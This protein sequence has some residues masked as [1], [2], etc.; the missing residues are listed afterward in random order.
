MDS[1]EEILR[2]VRGCAT[3]PV[4]K[5]YAF[6]ALVRGEG[7]LDDLCRA[8]QSDIGLTANVLRLANCPLFRCSREIRTV[9]EAAIRLGGWTMESILI[10]GAVAPFLNTAVPGYELPAGVLWRHAISLGAV[11]MELAEQ[12]SRAGRD[13]AFVAGLLAD[14]GKIVLGAFIE[15]DAE[16]IV[17]LAYERQVPFDEAER[18]VLGIDHPEVGAALLEHWLLPE[19]LVA[20]VRWHHRPDQ[21]GPWRRLAEHVHA[22]DVVCMSLGQSLGLDGLNYVC[23]E[24]A[25]AT[26][27]LTGE[28]T[29]EVMARAH[30]RAAE[31][32]A[33][34][35]CNGLAA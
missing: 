7:E 23:D 29:L 14:V 16:A 20:A 18:Q 10:A 3:L 12:E 26:A 35:L 9:R 24:A 30:E 5:H 13:T 15:A 21:A 25:M 32:S 34:W 11:A 8:V 2:Q 6:G 31:V 22:A 1:R 27:R 19:E 17:A 28:R 4:G 33:Q